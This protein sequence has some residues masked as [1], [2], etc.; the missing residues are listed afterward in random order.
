M[1]QIISIACL[2]IRFWLCERTE[3]CS[4]LA[5]EYLCGAGLESCTLGTEMMDSWL[6]CADPKW[7]LTWII[8][9]VVKL[10]FV[11]AGEADLQKSDA[12]PN[13]SAGPQHSS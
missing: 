13:T 8:L 9:G 4:T 7:N 3:I 10:K 12:S 6:L 2:N 5:F 1:I 11:A